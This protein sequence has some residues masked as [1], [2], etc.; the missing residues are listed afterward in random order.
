MTSDTPDTAPASLRQMLAHIALAGMP[1]PSSVNFQSDPTP[2]MNL[3]FY[4]HAED[5]RP[6]LDHF[7]IE[8]RTIPAPSDPGMLLMTVSDTTW[9]GWSV[10]FHGSTRVVQDLP[11]DGDTTARLAAV[12]T[13]GTI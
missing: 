1:T 3:A 4:G 13:V 6:W 5:A 12:T 2:I 11:L 10:Q 7:G 9:H 8:W